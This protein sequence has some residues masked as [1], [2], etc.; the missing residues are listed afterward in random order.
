MTKKTLTAEQKEEVATLIQKNKL[1]LAVYIRSQFK[2]ISDSDME[3]C[4]QNLF[5]RTYDKY[6]DFQKSPNKTGWIFKTMKNIIREFCRKKKTP[7]HRYVS[8]TLKEDTNEEDY[9]D[10]NDMIFEI[11]TDHLDEEQIV[12]LILSKLNEKE[13]ALYKLRYNDKLST[14]KI[15]KQLSLPSGTVRGRLSDMK[16]KITKLVHSNELIDLIKRENLSKNFEH[17]DQNRHI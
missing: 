11:A 8:L 14:D 13:Q 6:N 16:K 10:E 17:S 15:A 2:D 1:R 7:S 9:I 5:L 4:F 3:D 12:K